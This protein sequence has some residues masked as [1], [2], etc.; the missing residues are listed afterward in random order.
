MKKDLIIIVLIVFLG[1]LSFAG[2]YIVNRCEDCKE[3]EL[4]IRYI[5]KK[6]EIKKIENEIEK[7]VIINSNRKFRDSLRAKYNPE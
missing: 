4:E 3:H 1:A 5:E 7:I 6:N 2:G